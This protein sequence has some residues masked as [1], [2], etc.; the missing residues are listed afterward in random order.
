MAGDGSFRNVPYIKAEWRKALGKLIIKS[1]INTVIK[2]IKINACS[3]TINQT[4]KHD[5]QL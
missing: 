1:Y 4:I 3:S 5:T 2:S